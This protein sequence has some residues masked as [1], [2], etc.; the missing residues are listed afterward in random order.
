MNL[1][2][3]LLEDNLADVMLLQKVLQKGDLA[4]TLKVVDTEEE[5][6]EKLEK[7]KP[8]VVLS[9][10]SLPSFNSM[11]ALRHVRKRGLDIPFILVTGTVSEEFA[12]ECIMA[13]A[14]DYILKSNMARLPSAIRN[15]FSRK[16]LGRE[17]EIIQGLHDKLHYAYQEIEEK[18]KS[19][20][21]SISYARRIQ[22]AILPGADSLKK[23][24]PKSFILYKPKYQIG[25][26]FYWFAEREDKFFIAVAD[27]TGHGIPGALMSMLG[28]SL[29][30]EIIQVKGAVRTCDILQKLNKGIC[31]ILKQDEPDI[32]AH[33]GMDIAICCVD[34]TEHT[35][36][37]SG[38]KRPL[39][40]KHKDELSLIKGDGFGIGGDGHGSER[41]YTSHVL[42]YHPGD[43]F[44]LY[45][46]GYADQF[47]GKKERKLMNRNLNK[48]L[49][50]THSFDIHE[51]EEMLY[52]WLD[53]WKG[54]LEQTDDI[55]IV[56]IQL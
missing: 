9:D 29:L 26:D 6:V 8:D 11:E 47:G 4:I 1:K 34:K 24:Y 15:A 35:L 41:K 36:E 39:F 46:D 40:F 14:D 16:E 21:E 27:C 30:N 7:F 50:S 45:S 38:A 17:K 37:F 5:F 53:R 20:N 51:Q 42:P 10:H 33:H 13:G 52:Q 54:D 44:Y 28:F 3:L 49:Q 19:I 32:K 12:V 56:G 25:G 31:K 22:E 48:L 43:I 18:N 23:I 2:I 55:L